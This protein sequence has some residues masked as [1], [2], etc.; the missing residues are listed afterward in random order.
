MT[1][2]SYQKEKFDKGIIN[3][4]CL[5]V[6]EDKNVNVFLKLEIIRFIHFIRLDLFEYIIFLDTLEKNFGYR[7]KF[8]KKFS[9]PINFQ[10]K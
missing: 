1:S 6:I 8:P 2:Y 7:Q 9:F 5:N 10:K 3:F 4:K